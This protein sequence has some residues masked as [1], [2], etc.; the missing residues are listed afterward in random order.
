M[1]DDR[2]IIDEA[3]SQLP[4]LSQFRVLVVDDNGDM[5]EIVRSMLHRLRVAEID[6]VESGDAAL[7]ML[8]D[9]SCD[10]VIVAMTLRHMDGIELVRRIR[11][12]GDDANAMVPMC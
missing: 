12:G 7:L 6:E 4:D 10:M 8:Q 1:N 2:E 5:R 9:F 11:A 3:D